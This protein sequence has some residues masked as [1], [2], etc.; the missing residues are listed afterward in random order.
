M[1][2]TRS[3]GSLHTLN[4]GPCTALVGT[5]GEE[6][7]QV[8]QLVCRLD[9]TCHARLLKTHIL[10][11][12]LTLLV[13][14]QLGDI[15][16]GSRSHDQHLGILVGNGSLHSLG[17]HVTRYGRC[18]INITYVE[19]GLVGQKIKVGNELALLLVGLNRTSRA[20]LLQRLLELHQKIVTTLGVLIAR[21]GLLLALADIVLYGLQ[22][23]QLQLRVDNTLVANGIH[24]AIDVR[25][26]TILEATQNV[27][28]CIG[29]ADIAEE[30]ISQAFAL[31]STLHQTGDID[32]LDGGGDNLAGVINLGQLN[33]SLI[34]YGDNTHIGLDC[35]ERE[36]CSLRLSV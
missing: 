9:Q 19:Y 22:I 24:R 17:V 7:L 32:N 13:I 6:C 4:E 1:D 25:N 18:L 31:R 3:L 23:L 30:L 2:D 33:E 36:I 12:H 11:E 8:E 29:V 14:L 27:D 28:D 35:T 15:G 5:S 16:L 20:T 21:C 34:G 10:Q 26:I